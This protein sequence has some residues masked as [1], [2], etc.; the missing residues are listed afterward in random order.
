M[1]RQID[2]FRSRKNRKRALQTR[3][4]KSDGHMLTPHLSNFDGLRQFVE[5]MYMR[6][7]AK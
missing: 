6:R 4:L 1:K 5:R 3:Q 2:Q 7:D